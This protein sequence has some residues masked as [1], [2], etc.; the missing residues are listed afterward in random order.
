MNNPIKNISII[1]RPVNNDNLVNLIPN[2]FRW[3][4]NRQCQ[5]YFLKKEFQRLQAIFPKDIFSQA[6]FLDEDNIFNTSQMVIT[7]G[8]DGTLIGLCRKLNHDIPILGINRGR[9]G[10]ITE[11]G[12]G[13]FYDQLEK[14]LCGSFV[15]EKKNLFSANII[16]QDKV[17]SENIFFNDAVVT[18][19]DIARMFSLSVSSNEEHIY[20]LSGDGI[21]V[22][23]PTG[24]TAY[25]LAAGGPIVNPKVEA[26]IITP[27][28][29]HGLTQ[30]PLVLQDNSLIKLKPIPPFQSVIL[31][32]DGQVAIQLDQSDTVIIK[33]SNHSVN[34]IKNP[35]KSYY[36]TL[37]EKFGYGK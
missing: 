37:K 36:R 6:H 17:I 13:E 31:T 32:L 1:L 15:T 26:L 7:L 27:I 22:S 23:S 19:N 21:I 25:S 30:R 9:L 2:L 20:N 16:R 3:L 28:S 29:P 5:I 34:F 8:G 10:F 18:K 4:N 24:S 11:F 12:Q 35:E 33:K 14:I